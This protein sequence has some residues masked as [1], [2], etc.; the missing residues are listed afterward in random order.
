MSLFTNTMVERI[1]WMLVHSLWMLAIPAVLFAALLWL[2]PPACSRLRYTA[3]VVTLAMMAILPLATAPFIAVTVVTGAIADDGKAFET[4][5]SLQPS[6][7]EVDGP[8]SVPLTEPNVAVDDVSEKDPAAD[9]ARAPVATAA[10]AGQPALARPT[11]RDAGDEA[12][13]SPDQAS[14]AARSDSLARVVRHVQ[15]CLPWAVAAW[16]LGVLAMSFRL[17]S[18]WRSTR[19]LKREGTQPIPEAIESLFAD[20]KQRVGGCKAARLV[21][22]TLVAVPSVVGHFRPLVLLPVSALT[23]LSEEQLR[24][25][26]AH[27]LAHV[28]RQDYLVNICQSVVETLLF[29]HPAVWWVSRR[30]REDREHCCDDVAVRLGCKASDLARAL[31]AVDAIRPAP[32]RRAIDAALI[33]AA[34][35]G[36]LLRRVRRLAA[37][38]PSNHVSGRSWIAGSVVL[39]LL[40]VVTAASVASRDSVAQERQSSIPDSGEVEADAGAEVTKDARISDGGRIDFEGGYYVQLA[41]IEELALNEP[42]AV[43]KAIWNSSGSVVSDPP[44]QGAQVESGL[45]IAE[46]EVAKR[47]Y[48]RA[49]MPRHTEI[50]LDVIGR[51]VKGLASQSVSEA[52]DGDLQANATAVLPEDQ[53]TI[54]LEVSL[55]LPAWRT[56][57]SFDFAGGVKNG[58]IMD[59]ERKVSDFSRYT[60]TGDFGPGATKENIRIIA[61]DQRHRQ[62]EAQET[63][64]E[65]NAQG[66]TRMKVAFKNTEGR[67]WHIVVQRRTATFPIVFRGVPL[68]PGKHPGVGV[69][70][71]GTLL[72][73]TVLDSQDWFTTVID[74]QQ[75][76]EDPPPEVGQI[77][78][79]ASDLTVSIASKPYSLSTLLADPVEPLTVEIPGAGRMTLF[80]V[81]ETNHDGPGWYADGSPRLV[82]YDDEG[83]PLVRPSADDDYRKLE[84]LFQFNASSPEVR[85][86]SF[87]IRPEDG[88]GSTTTK[89]FKDEASGAR[90][91][92]FR[93]AL[94]ILDDRETEDF[95]V[96]FHA[97]SLSTL[98]VL[99]IV[100][101]PEDY[102]SGR[103]FGYQPGPDVNDVAF[104][105]KDPAK[106]SI[107]WRHLVM[108][109][110][111]DEAPS[112]AVISGITTEGDR[113]DGFANWNRGRVL[114]GTF[115]VP[116]E[117]KLRSV[118]IA[119][120]PRHSLV[121]RNVSVWSG[122]GSS[123]FVEQLGRAPVAFDS[124]APARVFLRP[125]GQRIAEQVEGGLGVPLAIAALD[126]IERRGGLLRFDETAE[127]PTGETLPYLTE[128][129]WRDFRADELRWVRPL[130][131]LTRLELS[132]EYVTDDSLKT[133]EHLTTLTELEISRSRHL[134]TACLESIGKLTELR[135]LQVVSPLRWDDEDYHGEDFQ[136]LRGLKKIVEWEPYDWRIDDAGI[137]WLEDAKDLAMVFG[138]GPEVTD[139]GFAALADKFD[140]GVIRLGTT[141]ITDASFKLLENHPELYWLQCSS[142]NLT[143]AAIDSAVTIG[144]LRDLHLEGSQVTDA[145]VETLIE[146]LPNLPR[147]RTV[148]LEQTQVSAEVVRR[149]REARD[150]LR[151]LAS[152]PSVTE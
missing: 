8:N 37:G 128:I 42:G 103:S 28:K 7:V 77:A 138:W 63:D 139:R 111:S 60:A 113:V 104:L 114:V 9:P 108:F 109:V 12:S 73:G 22:S 92:Q 147:L 39:S 97:G 62:L 133:I 55:K 105:I 15:P 49:R 151:V 123:A 44:F 54:D 13:S 4:S 26:L 121:F 127:A 143:D 27:E 145:G 96:D 34:D 18:G 52:T 61:F 81:R 41:A 146:S 48:V 80:G 56:V 124:V 99:P 10:A 141:K 50:D 47:F 11:G 132:S 40:L 32:G 134:T 87:R 75:A 82:P 68:S 152:Q 79:E 23:G 119:T 116:S 101:P 120:Q 125:T 57:A 107:G 84:A 70:V 91:V 150:G 98:A 64:S 76:T 17:L 148:N 74:P 72:S 65:V 43:S 110:L 88:S 38:P 149:L 85:V 83:L 122:L 135:E 118:E 33:P 51:T 126:E 46:K 21:Q 131:G 19:R 45:A 58:V 136:H 89:P 2:I 16:M 20:V 5:A 102:E 137:A 24:A 6:R 86:G 144:N 71:R 140:L 14:T 66:L 142:P 3:G 25:I 36:S 30:V 90:G 130:A 106:T 112:G 93:Q 31:V 67:P 95:E 117:A 69:T 29:Y 129:R 59:W 100:D 35:G 1:G 53:K 115:D 94:N 78:K